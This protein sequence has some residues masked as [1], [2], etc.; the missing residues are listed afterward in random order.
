MA[1]PLIGT[2]ISHYRILER[3]GGGGMGVVYKAQDSRL[4]RFVALKFL[5]DELAND[6][7]ALERF[8][9]EAKAASALNHPN[10]CT[11]YDIG[12][13]KGRAFIAMEFLDGATLKHLI[14]GR[15]VELE[16]LL[17]IAV[18]AAEAL[19]AAHSENI[20]HRD[21]KPA[22]IFVTK[23]GHA[24]I[25]DFG[26]AKVAS[27]KSAA[28][29]P[30]QQATLATESAHLTSPG[31]A[32]GTVAYMS[33]EQALGK[34]LDSRTDLFSFGVV[35]YEMA[36][37]RLPFKGDTSAAIFDSILHK[38][39]IPAV[40]LNEDVPTDL[41]HVI[42]RAIEKDRNLRYQHASDM[43]AELQRLKRDTDSG[44][45]V[46]VQVAEDLAPEAA[47]TAST[48]SSSSKQKAVSAATL[49]GSAAQSVI[50]SGEPAAFAGSKA[51]NLS[52]ISLKTF[53]ALAAILVVVILVVGL[54]WRSTSAA[55][56]TDKDTIVLADFINTTSDPVF[57]GTLRQGLT[58]QLEQ[59][60]FL[61]I[62][63]EHQVAE[64]LG[65]MGQPA[66]ARLT[67]ELARQVCERTSSTALIQGSISSL[68]NQYVVGLRAVNC[69]N[70]DSLANEQETAESKE[71]VLK[72]LSNATARLRSS[73]G[74]SLATVQKYDVPLAEA[75]TPSLEALGNFTLGAQDMKRGD[76]LQAISHFSKAVEL[77]S[78]FSRAYTTMGVAYEN[79]GD[80]EHG[81]ANIKKG[82]E[83]RERSSKRERLS[84][85]G[86]YYE[87]TGEFDKALEAFTMLARDYP[88]YEIGPHE[89]GWT[90]YQMGQFDRAI[91]QLQEAIRRT[92]NSASYNVLVNAYL[93]TEHLDEA[94]FTID[95]A[96]A[97]KFDSI[98][99]RYYVWAFL[100]NDQATMQQQLD[101]S[102]GK[103]DYENFLLDLQSDTEVFHGRLR[104]ARECSQ[105]AVQ[106][107][108]QHQLLGAA[109]GNLLDLAISEAELGYPALAQEDSAAALKI[110]TDRDK[111]A[112]AALV[113]A[114]SANDA[115]SEA[116]VVELERQWPAS[117]PVKFCVLPS[118][119]ALIQLKHANPAKALDLLEA[120][121]PYD[122][123]FSSALY[124]AYLRGEVLLA[125]RRPA[126]AAV[127]Y[128]KL[129][130][131]RGIVRNDVKGALAHLGLARAY[132]LQGNTAK[133]RSAYQDFFSLWK[134]ADPDIPIFIAAKA[135][136]AKLQ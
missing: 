43:R 74:E 88:N 54:Y 49:S 24:K 124:P 117:M 46:A 123:A 18:Q 47:P 1:D 45:S 109:A 39:P 17:N 59:S 113:F 104:R 9:R 63:S 32:L 90:L 31:T 35:L 133:S 114:R 8:R 105:R 36:T 101:W 96:L 28:I 91:P 66:S 134:D 82:F 77:D 30:D 44:R 106:S 81:F 85:E 110:T 97:H 71:L 67:N 4:D 111:Q 129:L 131:H 19:D 6:R 116:L 87:D 127:E 86:Y 78:N 65:F 128:Q 126:E 100:A 16:Q 42:N 93:A 83:L 22:N 80:A 64:A 102:A 11:I 25:L 98:R 27:G 103:A 48:K 2:T 72:A 55:K 79:L 13:E 51:R 53:I 92:A 69:H 14:T 15:P 73:L 33:P 38:S 56:L 121:R 122:L 70:G 62:I 75:T 60:P 136:Y 34:E 99:D 40:R 41:E 3:L 76:E 29:Y 52:S 118:I 7:Q 58:T 94:K 37:G 84:I 10:I 120:A 68:G 26:L 132:N 57:D 112:G 12:E 115:R 50:P 89:S 130:N 125:L 95:Q 5:P 23:R 107:A 61:R 135:E 21:I 119:R 108:K 20:I